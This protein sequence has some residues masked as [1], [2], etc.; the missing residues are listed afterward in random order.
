MV[1]E[2]GQQNVENCYSVILICKFHKS[3]WITTTITIM[4][5]II[6]L[7]WINT[8]FHGIQHTNIEYYLVQYSKR[9]L[10]VDKFEP[11]YWL[12]FERIHQCGYDTYTMTLILLFPVLRSVLSKENNSSDI[13]RSSDLVSYL[14]H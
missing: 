8:F 2:H 14:L 1:S 3:T 6:L 5:V 11:C 10:Q 12:R 9:I 13:W 7:M 4:I